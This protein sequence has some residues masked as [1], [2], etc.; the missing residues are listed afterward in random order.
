MF[1]QILQS[2]LLRSLARGR[3]CKRC[4]RCRRC[5]APQVALCRLDVAFRCLSVPFGAFRCLLAFRYPST[6]A[7][8]NGFLRFPVSNLEISPNCC[9]ISWMNKFIFPTESQDRPVKPHGCW[10]RYSP[11]LG[12]SSRKC[13]RSGTVR[14]WWPH[15]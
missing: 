2:Q 15:K 11:F 6:F 7:F 5:T 8:R 4:R 3:R 10:P 14:N 13:S 9:G 1:D 12:S